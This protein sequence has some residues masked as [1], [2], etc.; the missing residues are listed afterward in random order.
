MMKKVV[1]R[2][3][4]CIL[5]LIILLAAACG[6]G[7]WYILYKPNF[8][9]S[10]RKFVYIYEDVKDFDALCQQLQDSAACID[11]RS[12][13]IL[14]DYRKYP[15][16]MKS[17]RY[18]VEPE[19]NNNTLI[20][21]LRLGQQSPIR[22]IFNNIRLTAD[23]AER[24]SQQLMIDEDD[25]LALF[26]DSLYCDSLGFTTATIGAMFIPNTY[27]VYWNISPKKL[28][29]RM[30]RE[31]ETFWTAERRRKAENIRLNPVEIAVLASIVEEETAAPD[32]YSRVAG[33]YINRLRKGMLLQADPTVK[34]ALGDFSLRR[35]LNEHLTVESPYNTYLNPGL[36]PGPI[37]IPSP[38]SIDA[39][40]NYEHHNY[41]YMCAKEDFSGRHNFAVTLAEHAR[42]AD[43]YHAALNRLR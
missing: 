21:H 2:L 22:L 10:E 26:A 39:V 23:L 8:K 24:L 37:R 28:F 6:G 19:M 11:V 33:L 27:E 14:A 32:E 31:Y 4:W 18:A 5:A 3:I 13:R 15:A 17:G 16:N 1:K 43:R 42:N 38:R 29:D 25:L 12:F 36:P 35:I 9:P 41:L 20:N 7:I 30:K 34:Y 40:L